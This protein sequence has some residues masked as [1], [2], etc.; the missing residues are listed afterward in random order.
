MVFNTDCTIAQLIQFGYDRLE[1]L[2]AMDKAKDRRD[3]NEVIECMER[4]DNVL[5]QQQQQQQQQRQHQHTV[6]I[7]EILAVSPSLDQDG[8]DIIIS[9]MAQSM[10][11]ADPHWD[12]SLVSPAAL[13]A[14]GDE[15][16]A[17][18]KNLSFPA[19]A[20]QKADDF[21]NQISS[22]AFG[23]NMMMDDIVA[24]MDDGDDGNNDD[25]G[26]EDEHGHTPMGPTPSGPSKKDEDS[27][28]P[29]AYGHPQKAYKYEFN[30]NGNPLLMG[31]DEKMGEENT[32]N[33]GGEAP[34]VASAYNPLLHGQG[35]KNMKNMKNMQFGQNMPPNQRYQNMQNQGVPQMPS[36]D[37]NSSNHHHQDSPKEMKRQRS[38]KRL[39]SAKSPKSAK[40]QKSP[41]S[42]KSP[43]LSSF[44]KKR[45]NRKNQVFGI[46]SILLSSTLILEKDY[47]SPIPN[48]LIKLKKELFSNG[49]HLIEGIFRVAPNN[50]DCKAVEDE[51]NDGNF[52]N[53]DFGAMAGELVANLIKMWFRQLPEPVLQALSKGNKMETA[54]TKQHCLGILSGADIAEPNKSYFLWLLDLSADIIEHGSVNKMSPK[55]MAVVLAPNMY[56]PGMFENPMKAMTFSV[57]VV[58]FMQMAIECRQSMR[59][60]HL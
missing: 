29:A 10:V 16:E 51:L 22:M 42:P 41:K 45:K 3:I 58:K 49:G 8:N 14:M 47:K 56:N 34:V 52:Q 15:D 13:D 9:P 30:P 27:P 24:M 37:S 39:K 33:H 40:P 19:P 17:L 38:W 44:N 12:G 53:M 18:M 35:M 28:P 23:N 50:D 20:Q 5:V 60:N 32:G 7:S 11:L 31:D 26:D 1:I 21:D 46:E 55:A 57:A 43:S 54:K 25:D 36:H 48:F 6:Q 4:N 59:N 2:V